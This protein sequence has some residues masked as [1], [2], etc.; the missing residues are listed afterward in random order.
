MKGKIKSLI[1]H[2]VLDIIFP[3]RYRRASKAA[4]D[5][6]LVVFVIYD[7]KTLPGSFSVIRD[8]ISALGYRVEEVYLHRTG[9]SYTQYFSN[10]ASMVDAIAPAAYVFLEEGNEVL[11]NLPLRDGTK[12]VQLWHGCG[13]FKKFGMSTAG[14]LYGSN[15]AEQKAHPFHGNYSLVTV[16]SPE[17][18]W[19]YEEAMQIPKA[20]GVVRPLGISRTDRFFDDEYVCG[21]RDRALEMYPGIEGRRAILYAPTFRGTMLNAKAPDGLDLRALHDALGDGYVVLMRQHPFVKKENRPVIPED[22][23]DFVID[24]TDTLTSDESV[25]CSDICVTDYSSII[26]E[27]SLLD[28]PMIFFSYD[29]EDYMD[30]RGFYYDY[31]ELTPGPVVRETRELAGAVLASGEEYDFHRLREFREK[32]MSSC[33]GHATER[34]LKEVGIGG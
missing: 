30:W 31:D 14:L 17:V 21:A 29:I 20:S 25:I 10:C 5:D 32:F 26:F 23:G 8:R 3:R 13:A 15:A 11:S 1:K 16:S 22:L 9:A 19:A 34:I 18:V 6:R 12:V 2:I 33:D 24:V 28:R 27:Y 7:G 4:L